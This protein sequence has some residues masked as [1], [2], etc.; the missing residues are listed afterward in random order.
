MK[1]LLI[2]LSVVMLAMAQPVFAKA[3]DIGFKTYLYDYKIPK[4]LHDLCQKKL[5]SEQGK[6]YN[7]EHCMTVDIEL[8]KTNYPWIDNAINQNFTDPSTKKEVRAFFD[9]T[10]KDVYDYLKQSDSESMIL[11]RFEQ[12]QSIKLVGTSPRLTQIMLDAYEYHGGAHGMP[13]RSFYTFD[14][15]QKK[16]LKLDDILVSPVKKA[17]FEKI[18]FE[19][20]KVFF[21]NY[22]IENE[23]EYKE[24]HLDEHINMWEFEL[25]DNFYFT[26][27]GLTLSYDP[28]QLGP[29][30]MGFVILNIDKAKLKGVIKDEYLNQTF[31]NFNDENWSKED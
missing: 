11:N 1:K 10:A 15:Q 18:A 23:I 25:T 20:F 4:K 21:K 8:I 14:M 9:E 19:Q 30:A 31:E 22:H 28:Y 6:Q 7:Q 13:S 3:P 16:E 26:P 2:P 12:S 27:K 29:Y 24:N 5:K 17:Q